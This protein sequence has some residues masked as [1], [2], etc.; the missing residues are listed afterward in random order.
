[1]PRS[2]PPPG[3]QPVALIFRNLELLDRLRYRALL[4]RRVIDD[5]DELGRRA[6]EAVDGPGL[7]L[8]LLDRSAAGEPALAFIRFMAGEGARPV[9]AAAGFEAV[10]AP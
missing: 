3:D 5:A 4:V 7:L 1:M 6:A 10:P 8:R 2:I 9:W